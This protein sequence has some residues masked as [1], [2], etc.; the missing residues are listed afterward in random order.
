[1]A[2]DWRD[3]NG[4]WF[5]ELGSN[6][7]LTA[8]E[9]GSLKGIYYSAVGNVPQEYPLSGRFDPTPTEAWT[10]NRVGVP[11]GWAVT[12][13]YDDDDTD[14]PVHIHSTT[15]WSGLFFDDNGGKPAK[16]ITQW[17]LTRSMQESNI[18]ES[19]HVGNDTFTR[20]KPTAAEIAKAR[21]LK[22]GSPGDIFAR[23]NQGSE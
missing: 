5:N 1:M 23:A 21:E 7:T 16:I 14:P 3:L 6:M 15:T 11:V 10:P 19:T 8:V 4:E 18:W 12:F 13:I 20:D 2:V 22:G 17:L 9:T